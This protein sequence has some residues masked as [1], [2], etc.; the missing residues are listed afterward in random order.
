MSEVERIEA[1]AAREIEFAGGRPVLQ[2]RGELLPLEDEGG[3]LQELGLV[4]ECGTERG[5]V[6]A[7]GMWVPESWA[8]AGAG[9]DGERELTV[10]ICLRA[11]AGGVR[12]VGMVVRRVLDVSAGTLLREDEMVCPGR[13]AMVKDRVTTVHREAVRPAEA[14]VLQEVA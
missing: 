4:R 14:P 5:G 1:V 2:C 13:V 7:P 12:R 10:M 6:P 3:V 8:D 11:G 9:F